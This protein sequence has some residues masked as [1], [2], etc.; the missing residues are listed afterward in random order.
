MALH[1][2]GRLPDAEAAY[3]SILQQVPDHGDAL[4]RLGVLCLQTGDYATAA[5]ILAAAVTAAPDDAGR[6]S[7]L[8]SALRPPEPAAPKR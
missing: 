3:R 8:A 6:H 4:N 2:A 5:T 1:D 7:N